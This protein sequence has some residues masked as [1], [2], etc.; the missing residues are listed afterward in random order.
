MKNNKIKAII[1]DLDGTLLNS[2]EDIADCAN[3]TIVKFGAV[4]HPCEAYRYYVGN[5]LATLMQR[6]MPDQ[7]TSKDLES[8]VTIFEQIYNQRWSQKTRPYPGII[9]MLETLQK[10]DVKIA[11]LSNKP[12]DFTQKCVKYFFPTISFSSVAGKKDGVQPKP[13][14]DSTLK[15]L[16]GLMTEARQS[17]F[18]GDSSVDIMTGINA[19]MTTVG[20]DWGFRTTIELKEA[21]ADFIVSSP[22]EIIHYVSTL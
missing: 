14:P 8:S 2:L 12:D 18:V 4:P 16:G 9:D 5:G 6:V 13:D 1:F 22:R 17:M 11:I 7:A 10:L 19:G 15:M 20:V 3:Q 21:G